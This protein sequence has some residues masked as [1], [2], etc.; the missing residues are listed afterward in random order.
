MFA[1]LAGG[2]IRGGQVFGSSDRVAFEP[3]DH[4]VYPE[5]M[6]ATVYRALGIDQ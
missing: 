2:G 4:L 3:A 1:L 6:A 5:D